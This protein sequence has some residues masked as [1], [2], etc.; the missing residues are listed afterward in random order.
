M[1]ENMLT[2]ATLRPSPQAKELKVK[3]P[4]GHHV[5]L[6]SVKILTG[7]PIHQAVSEALDLYFAAHPLEQA[8]LDAGFTDADS[9]DE[10]HST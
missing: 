10:A 5:K 3:L 9:L 6:M 8:L 7:K 4:A 2:D 1:G